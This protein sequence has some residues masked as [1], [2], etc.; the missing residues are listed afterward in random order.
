LFQPGLVIWVPLIAFEQ[1]TAQSIE[2]WQ[3]VKSQNMLLFL[4]Y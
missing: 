2:R 1:V 4:D 3:A